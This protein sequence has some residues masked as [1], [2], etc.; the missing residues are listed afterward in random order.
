MDVHVRGRSLS[1]TLGTF[2]GPARSS[3]ARKARRSNTATRNASARRRDGGPQ[4]TGVDEREGW[5]DFAQKREWFLSG[6][7]IPDGRSRTQARLDAITQAEALGIV[8]LESLDPG[9]PPLRAG[10]RLASDGRVAAPRPSSRRLPR[11]S[12]LARPV[13]V[14]LPR[15]ATETTLQV[16]VP[17]AAL[18]RV[19]QASIRMFRLESASR[20]WQI[21]PR[22]GF[23]TAG[24]YA[25]ARLH[26]PGIY[27]PV[28]LPLDRGELA[29]LVRTFNAGAASARHEVAPPWMLRRGLWRRACASGSTCRSG[30]CWP[31]WSR[32]RAP[33][34][35]AGAARWSPPPWRGWP[36]GWWRATGGSWG[37][38]TS[39]DASSRWPSDRTS[40]SS[41][42]R[43]PPTAAYGS[44]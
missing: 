1:C 10:A 19:D 5:E 43:G 3:M 31:S 42:T 11:A 2:H 27:A 28:G 37:R 7:A 9:G 33:G 39:M 35:G 6:R 23:A 13:E 29:A 17:A 25:W 24:G 44:R 12:L 8:A 36:P 15:R 34:K 41:S 26:R 30:T 20:T 18:A 40:A 16:A 32:P 38:G 21:I 22:S 14:R 4:R